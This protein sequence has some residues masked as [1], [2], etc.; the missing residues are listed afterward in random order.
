MQLEANTSLLPG[1]ELV[2]V[3]RYFD[4]F[5]YPLNI[6][7]LY[8][9]LSVKVDRIQ[10]ISNTLEILIT[11]QKIE[12]KNGYYALHNIDLLLKNRSEG[13]KRFEALFPR[14]EKT[15]H[16]LRRFPFVQFIGLSGSLS[17][18]YAPEKA[19]IDLFIITRKNRLWLCRTILHLFKKISFL[20]GSQHWYCM[21]YFV[22]ETALE[23][24]E[25][26]YFTA[27]E[28]ATLKPLADTSNFHQKLIENNAHWMNKVLPNY[29][30][31]QSSDVKEV[32][33]FFAMKIFEIFGSGRLNSFL[34][35]LTDKKWRRK[36]KKKNYPAED[37]E[38][39]FKTRINISKNHLHNYQKKL[40][41]YLNKIQQNKKEA[42]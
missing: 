39:A 4:Y 11:E 40:L 12:E 32:R 20:K 2:M 38:L 41:D 30:Y 28:L 24:E 15:A 18:G 23:I 9:F 14:I 37:Y 3:L 26:N 22:D 42:E 7:E 21:N 27:I 35:H 8:T 10:I 5:S 36:W 13:K 1:E 25:Q 6:D 33:V 34:M 17:K 16:R 19:D 29:Q 31:K